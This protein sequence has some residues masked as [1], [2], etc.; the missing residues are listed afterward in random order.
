MTRW[1]DEEIEQK[2]TNQFS[3]CRSQH[4]VPIPIANPILLTSIPYTFDERF[5][6]A[7]I[8]H[9]RVHRANRHAACVQD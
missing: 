5:S 8:S 7:T 6:T 4:R 2:I 3:L 1:L 9:K